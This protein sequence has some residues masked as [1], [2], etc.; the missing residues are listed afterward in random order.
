MMVDSDSCINTIASKL[1]T[2]L[3][4][5][6]VKH[7]NPYKVIWIDATSIDAQERCQIP[8]QFATYT[9]NVWCNIL[10]MDVDPIILGRPWLFDLDVTIYERTYQFSFVHNDKKVKLMLNQPK[11]PT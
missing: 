9:D 10:S 5:R 7:T 4:M 8:I 1:I 2:T 6:P 3:G 11:Q